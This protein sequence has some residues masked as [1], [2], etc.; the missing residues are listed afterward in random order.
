MQT[1]P[2]LVREWHPERNGDLTPETVS[3]GSDR[4]IWWRCAAHPEHEWR[5][6]PGNR[7]RNGTGCPFCA[8]GTTR[9]DAAS[10]LAGR[11]PEI[12]AEWDAE[13][14]PGRRVEQTPPSSRYKAGWRCSARDHRWR[15]SVYSRTND[16]KGCP[17]CAHTV[18]TRETSLAAVR[19][20][21]AAQWH[22]TRNGEV[23]PWDVGPESQ[24]PAHFLCGTCN[25]QWERAPA[26]IDPD[27]T[28]CPGCRGFVVTDQN[29]LTARRPDIALEWN[30]ELNAP[31][32]PET[33]TI[34][35]KGKVWWE[36]STCRFE[37]PSTIV[38]RRRLY[39]GGC[40]SCAGKKHL[41]RRYEEE[42][43]QR[44]ADLSRP[45]RAPKRRGPAESGGG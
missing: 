9:V 1:H 16:G 37:W 18:V 31:L 30:D 13:A 24:I 8:L 44:R 32:T 21:V 7:T 4:M 23:T 27:K 12:A 5:A 19:P 39:P 41:V 14:N 26:G 35:Q 36:C 11:F 25:T 38:V 22:P 6:R 10:S 45:S 2:D 28:G 15:A 42:A 17:A 3:G 33:V 43:R 29:S 20:E 40:P 34:G